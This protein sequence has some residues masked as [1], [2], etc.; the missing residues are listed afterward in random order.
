[1]A[2]SRPRRS[3]VHRLLAPSRPNQ[4][5]ARENASQRKPDPDGVLLVEY[6]DA[7]GD[8]GNGYQIGHLGGET[9]PA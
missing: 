2:V 4:G 6:D 8:T 1:M 5:Q 7:P 9:A 3:S